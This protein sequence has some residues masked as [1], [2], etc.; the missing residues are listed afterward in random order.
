MAVNVPSTSVWGVCATD[1]TN[2]S[3]GQLCNVAK[4][5]SLGYTP[6]PMPVYP[7][8]CNNEEKGNNPM[9]AEMTVIDRSDSDKDQRSYLEHRLTAVDRKKDQ[10]LRTQFNLDTP[11]RPA[12][13]KELIDAIKNGEYTLNEKLTNRVD[14][15]EAEDVDGYEIIYDRDYFDYDALTGI[16]FT[17]FPPADR[18]AWAMARD[19]KAEVYVATKDAIRILP[20]ADGLKAVQGFDKWTY[21]A[22]ST[23]TAQ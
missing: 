18:R 4:T 10:D 6:T 1:K 13:Y 23:T 3:L 15:E 9:Y 5:N 14:E 17:N 21:T 2:I 19:A 11:N 12:T 7:S 16:N 22:P 20:V 8:A